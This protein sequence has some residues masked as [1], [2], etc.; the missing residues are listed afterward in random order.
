MCWLK[1][2]RLIIL[3]IKEDKL[4]SWLSGLDVKI[5]ALEE[6]WAEHEARETALFGGQTPWVPPNAKTKNEQ[7]NKLKQQQRRLQQALDAITR[8]REEN[9]SGPA[10]KAIAS[11]TDPDAR[12]MKG[13]EGPSKPNY[14]AQLAVDEANGMIVA[15]DVNDQPDDTGQLTPMIDQATDNTGQQPE[16]VSADSGYNTG[17]ELSVLEDKG[18]ESYLPDASTNSE[19]KPMDQSAREA[20]TA[21]QEAKPLTEEQWSALPKNGKGLFDKSAF[22]YDCQ[23]DV[24]RCPAGHSLRK[25][26]SS[27]D[28]KK[29]GIAIRKQYGDCKACSTCPVAAQCC[30]DP[31]KGRTINRD[32]YEAHRERLRQRMA[33]ERGRAIYKRRRELSE[34]RFGEIKHV[35]GIRRFMRRGIEQVK[36]EWS[37]ICTAVNIGILLRHWQQTAP[38]L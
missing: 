25:F 38:Y 28:K 32:Q 37:L 18:I 4:E 12:V 17:P 33:S 7:L 21:L 15:A 16:V 35:K 3:G 26:R 9:P 20:I 23:K 2:N 30:K 31:K 1:A 6:E 11:I 19:V 27:Q 24:Y 22:V 8:R 14:N 5:I 10:P 36:T 34:P 13:K 29:W